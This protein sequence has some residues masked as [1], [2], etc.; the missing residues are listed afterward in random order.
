MEGKEETC[1]GNPTPDLQ[2]QLSQTAIFF[3]VDGYAYYAEIK[4]FIDH[5]IALLVAGAGQ[6]KVIIRHPDQTFTPQGSSKIQED[7]TYL[8]FS[9]VVAV[10]GPLSSIPIG[11][12][13]G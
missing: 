5:H 9:T 8:D 1:I 7:Y 12:T 6:T 3:T 11:F 10:T 2:R 13:L 4:E